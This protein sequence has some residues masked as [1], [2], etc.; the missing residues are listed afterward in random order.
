MYPGNDKIKNWKQF[1]K[2]VRSKGCDLFS[3]LDLFPN[4]ICVTGCQR[5]GT[6][7][8][9]RIITQSD[10]IVDYKFSN[11]DELDAAMILSGKIQ[12]LPEGRY[13]FQTT[14]ANEC[15]REY[16]ERG[17]DFRIVWV[18]RNPFS[19]IYS[20]VHHWRGWA[21]NELF[22]AC[23]T[24]FLEGSMRSRFDKFGILGVPKLIRACTAFNGKISQLF[25]LKKRLGDSRIIVVEY[26]RL[27]LEKETLFPKIFDFFDLRYSPEYTQSLNMKSIQKKN[28]LSD[29]EQRTI[30]EMCSPIYEKA[31]ELTDFI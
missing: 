17:Q 29:K 12:N 22:L 14:Y 15:Y 21:L 9:S 8:L 25:E 7:I 27:I 24:D 30:S 31:S 11:D 16:F 13:C 1:G 26:D 19:V 23:G 10:E 18:L 20:L 6:T 2:K 4:C 28:K 3:R 5:S